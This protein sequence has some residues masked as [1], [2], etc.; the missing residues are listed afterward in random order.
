MITPVILSGGAGTRLW[1]LSRELYPKQLLPL[2]GARTMLQQTV[3][4]LEGL[5][6]G[7]PVVVCNE[8]HRFLVAEQLRQLHIEPRATLLEPFGRNTAPAIALAAHAALKGLAAQANA[9]DPVLLVLPADHVIRDVAAFHAAVRAALR[10]G[11][12]GQLVT[13]GIVATRAGDRLRLHPARR[14]R[15]RGVPHRPL[16]REAR[17]RAGARVRRVRRLLLEQRHVPVPRAA[18]T[19]RSWSASRRRWRAS[20]SRR[21]AARDADLDFT[22]HRSGAVR[23]LPGRLD[24]LRGHGEDRGCG[25]RA[26]GCRL[27]RRR[28]LVVAARGQ[29]CRRARQRHPR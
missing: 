25:G 7:A 24:R 18:A 17:R 10:G 20:A 3:L 12:G 16:R 29:R 11:R 13:F 9:L 6:A 27:E 28:L 14:G 15:G 26:A 1:P 4:R 19:C 23:S 21:S 2:T 5:A 22:A 8:A